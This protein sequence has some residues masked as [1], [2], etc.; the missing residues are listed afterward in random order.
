[1]IHRFGL[2]LVVAVASATALPAEVILV[3]FNDNGSRLTP[4]VGEPT[5]NT[6][7]TPPTSATALADT[8]GEETDV[9]LEMD[10][11][12]DSSIN[13][14]STA[15]TKSWVDEQ[16]T[17]DY[18]WCG[19]GKAVTLGGLDSNLTYNVELVAANRSQYAPSGDYT[20]GDVTYDDFDLNEDGWVDQTIMVWNDVTPDTSGEI[21]ITLD[22]MIVDPEASGS[23]LIVNALRLQSV[24]EPS[25]VVL[26]AMGLLALVFFRRSAA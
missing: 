18:L 11:F 16:A 2:A 1:M 7:A 23:V 13:M 19:N 14:S 25:C 9:T 3:D 15:W 20:I 6:F 4:A 21:V 26:I 17:M 8:D 10:G 22:G 12:S 24:P 5:W